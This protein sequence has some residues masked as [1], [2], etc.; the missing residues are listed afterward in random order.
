MSLLNR[1]CVNSNKL[2]PQSNNL[3]S[4]IRGY[5]GGVKTYAV[6]NNLDFAW[7]KRYY[8]RIIRNNNEYQNFKEYI[9]SNISNY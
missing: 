3:G 2:G 8:D 4:I 9:E 1:S 7:Q 5:K 6:N